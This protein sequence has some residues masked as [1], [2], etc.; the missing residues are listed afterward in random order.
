MLNQER[1]NLLVLTVIIGACTSDSKDD[2]YSGKW[3]ERDG[4]MVCDGYLTRVEDEDHCVAEVPDDWEKF[5]FDGK[6]YYMQPL[7]DAASD[8]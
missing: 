1:M 7:R 5:T 8:T 6:T 4:V 3:V 2:E